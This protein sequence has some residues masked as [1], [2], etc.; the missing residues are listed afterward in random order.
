MLLNN[1]F[2]NVGSDTIKNTFDKYNIQVPD[3]YSFSNVNLVIGPNGSGK[4][5]FLRA[6]KDLYIEDGNRKVLYGYFPSLSDRKVSTEEKCIEL[7]EYTLAEAMDID[8]ASFDDFFK[9]IE[10]IKSIT[11]EDINQAYKNIC[12]GLTTLCVLEGD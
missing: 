7:P 5:R 2:P 10:E 11:L 9:E 6:I 4:T 1:L 8:I 12:E 3:K